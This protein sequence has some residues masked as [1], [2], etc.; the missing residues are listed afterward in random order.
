[1]T[2]ALWCGFLTLIIGML[3]LDLGVLHR[4]ARADSVRVAL[5]W[6]ILWVSV[7]LLFNV[8][9]YFIY[10]NNWL[11][12]GP[13]RG[14]DLTGAQAALQFFTG[15]LVE[16]SLSVDNIFVIAVI[17]SYFGVPAIYQHRVLFWGILGAILM[18]GAM[19]LGATALIHRFEWIIYVF[20]ALLVVTA[21]RMAFAGDEKIEPERNPFVRLARRVW[22]VTS[23]YHGERFFVRLDGRSA[24]TPL[25][26]V[27]ILVE[28]TDVLFAID[29]I[30]AIFAITSDPFIVFSSNVFAIL[31][32]RSLFFALSGALGLFRYLKYSL[33]VVLGFVGVKMLLADVYHIPIGISLSII[34][35]TLAAGIIASLLLAPRSTPASDEP[36][37]DETAGGGTGRAQASGLPE[38]DR[39]GNARSG[40]SPSR[41]TPL[42]VLVVALVI[43]LGARG[44]CVL[45]APQSA[46]L[47]DHQTNMGWAAYAVEHGPAALYD[48]P[49]GQPLVVRV[50]DPGTG[51]LIDAPRVNAHAYNYPPAAAYAFWLKGRLWQALDSDVQTIEIPADLARQ[52][53][54]PPTVQGRVIDTPASRL[55]EAAPNV[56]FD[57]LLAAGV[58]ALVQRTRG[59]GRW[60]TAESI[61]FALTFLAPPLLIDSAYWG[62][63]DSWIAALLVWTLAWMWQGG[64]LAAGAAFG[65]ALVTKPQAIL[66]IPVLAFAL[67]SLWLGPGGAVR[68]ALGAAAK[69]AGVAA[70]VALAAAA[71]TML[72]DAQAEQPGGAWRWVQRSYVG[73][74]TD[75]R[76]QRTTMNA[77]NVWWFDLL[78]GFPPASPMAHF[79]NAV[80]SQAQLWGLTKDRVG[81]L[82][83]V[84]ALLVGGAL[85]A[86]RWRWAR[87]SWLAF[88]F[89]TTFAAFLLPT[90]V[91]ER[92]IF[93]CLPFLIA[94][95]FQGRFWIVPL[96]LLLIV[97]TAE[98][99]A[100]AWVGWS[101]ENDT[102]GPT[103]I[104][105]GTS[106]AAFVLTLIGLIPR[107]RAADAVVR[108]GAK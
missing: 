53:G 35:F 75:A 88:A 5:G 25:F 66:L 45:L 98:M 47:P 8:L 57:L 59:A 4:R 82:G 30:P 93:Y 67:L 50:R 89:F 71:P 46:Y 21:L 33:V 99:F 69:L 83:L 52:R 7:A 38:A 96:V 73:T 3:A 90:R 76:Y 68:A 54:L 40:P 51:K 58:A 26:L 12:S 44:L 2:I 29:S 56:V 28:S 94:L 87:D 100:Y 36:P 65:L 108:P 9:V 49:A 43:G 11:G 22:P 81:Q 1:M 85:C 16:Y 18:R 74:L 101:G 92:Y 24:M 19:I 70:A 102:R 13:I 91:H 60:G 37:A 77:F 39:P 105:A 72:H 97:A 107:A 42:S 31:G 80:D 10:E 103:A 15:Y 64:W 48:L 23:E 27:L 6:T 20:G 61:A 79:R 41:L 106:V 104:L 55:A 95:A 86:R 78:A 14:T 63:A 84:A 34:A 62:Q 32:L 17:F